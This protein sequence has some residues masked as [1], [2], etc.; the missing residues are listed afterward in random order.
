MQDIFEQVD[1]QLDADNVQKFWAKNRKW[2]I[3]SLVVLF[4]GLFAY[5]GWRDYR[6]QQ[7]QDA[8]EHFALARELLDEK[9]HGKSQQKLHDLQ[10]E[11]GGH[12]YAL[13]GRFLLA[14][15]LVDDGKVDAA[16]LQ[17]EQVAREAAFPTL[18]DL[19]LLSAAYLTANDV[20]RAEGFLARMGK[21]SPYQAHALE[22]K[23]LLAVQGGNQQGAL[24]HYQAARAL[25]PAG[26]TLR[27]RLDDRLERFSVGGTP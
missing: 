12:G 26:G 13:F 18:V 8:A 14:K 22:L 2:V 5:V 16:L 17:Y 27:S 3:G 20:G 23:G 6:A 10:K 1:E 24:V 25:T 21:Y 4:V 11:Y 19:A 9:N 15:S 7:S